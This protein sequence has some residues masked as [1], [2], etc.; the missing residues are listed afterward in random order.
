M[1]QV[2]KLRPQIER[3]GPKPMRWDVPKPGIEL[4]SLGIPYHL[5]LDVIQL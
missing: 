5:S 2:G 3:N 1:S 4:I